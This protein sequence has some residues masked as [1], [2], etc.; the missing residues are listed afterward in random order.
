[1]CVKSQKSVGVEMVTIATT[2][3]INA[4][5]DRCFDLARSVEVHLLG[6]VRWNEGALPLGGRT[7][8]LIN[9]GETVTWRAKHFGV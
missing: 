1:M 9:Q 5:V 2:T 8:G 7:S 4:P 3:V 6:N